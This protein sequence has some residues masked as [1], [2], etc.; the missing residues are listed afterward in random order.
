M[1][2][3]IMKL[4]YTRAHLTR[5][6]ITPEIGLA[7]LAA[8]VHPIEIITVSLLGCFDGVKYL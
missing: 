4:C 1:A 6:K 3:N 5:S 2:L 7:R 8:L